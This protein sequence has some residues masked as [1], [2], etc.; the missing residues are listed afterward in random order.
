MAYATTDSFY[1]LNDAVVNEGDSN[2]YFTIT[3]TGNISY[4]ERISISTYV[5]RSDT[6]REN[7]DFEGARGTWYYFEPNQTSVK[8][9]LDLI[10]DEYIEPGETFRVTVGPDYIVNGTGYNVGL[11]RDINYDGNYVNRQDYESQQTGYLW[12]DGEDGSEYATIT[13]IDDDEITDPEP[14]PEPTPE[15]EPKPEPE[16][17]P[18]LEDVNGD[19]FVDEVINYQMWTA[20]G[21]VDLK[22]SPRQNLFRRKLKNVECSQGVRK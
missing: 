6:A 4:P 22:K 7:I 9:P 12:I 14:T 17:E 13:I 15:P 21:G 3:R 5:S 10:D 20:S 1:T 2:A 18:E 16:P 8:V 11:Q 19:G